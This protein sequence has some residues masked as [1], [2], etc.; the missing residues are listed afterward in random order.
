MIA[1]TQARA[2]EPAAPQWEF[3]LTP[4]LWVA[5]VSGTLQTPNPRIPSQSASA[6]FGDILSH[7]DAIPFM[8]SAE[9]RYDRFGVMADFM[10]IS[11]EA[12]IPTNGPLFSSGGAKLTQFIGTMAGTYRVINAPGQAL[13]LGVGARAFGMS[14]Q[15]TLNSGLLQGFTKS[16]GASWADPIA[17]V[18]YHIDLSPQWGLTAYADGGGGPSS[19]YTW[20]VLGTV[21]WRVTDSM[22]MRIGYRNLQFQYQ[23]DKLHQNM[24]MSG[25][26]IGGTMQF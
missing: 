21:D 12:G 23:G 9:A 4:Y 6:G 15:F 16:P 1:A 7:L 25:P 26:I 11:V 20:Q 22:V 5:G 3:Y 18:R 19:Q 2:E 24:T 17:V 14:T 10:A 13:D 8:G